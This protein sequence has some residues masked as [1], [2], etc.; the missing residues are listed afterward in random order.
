MTSSKK[1]I[2]SV[3]IDLQFAIVQDYLIIDPTTTQ[4]ETMFNY[5]FEEDCPWTHVACRLLPPAC[6]PDALIRGTNAAAA[7][8]ITCDDE[9]ILKG[10]VRNGVDL[11]VPRLR[12]ICL[13]LKVTLPRAGEGSGKNG[14]V[15]KSDIVGVF[16]RHL[17]PDAD[18][19]FITEVFAKMMKQEKERLTPVCWQW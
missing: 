12:Q 17:W 15:L 3:P 18:D 13:S 7:F 16:I 8:E 6:L 9:W 14:S 10:A 2:I 1:N 5:S 19:D 4:V 11:T